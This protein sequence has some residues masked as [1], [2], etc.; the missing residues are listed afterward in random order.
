[1]KKEQIIQ[2]MKARKPHIP[3][4]T[5]IHCC[6][7]VLLISNYQPIKIIK[8]SKLSDYDT[9]ECPQCDEPVKPSKI[10]KD[11]SVTYVCKECENTFKIAVDGDLVE[12]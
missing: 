2:N 11:G 6:G 12:D 5:A 3:Q 4:F 10:N 7:S 9:L 1:M 8:M